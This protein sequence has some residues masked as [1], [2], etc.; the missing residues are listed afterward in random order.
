MVNVF[1][2]SHTFFSGFNNSVHY[3]FQMIHLDK[4]TACCGCH[5]CVSICPAQCIQMIPDTE[6]FLYPVPDES[7]CIDCGLCESVCPVL[8][9]PVQAGESVAFAAWN[10]D[11]AVREDSSSGGIFNAL[12]QRTFEKNGV[13]FGAAF[14]GSMTLCHQA[15]YNEA[16]GRL[17]RGSKYLQSVI[18]NAYLEARK[19]L[20]QG[21]QVLFSGTPCQI[22]G[23]YAFLRK[24]YDNLLT[25]D[26]VCHGV[27]SPKVFSAYRAELEGQHGAKAQRIA[28]RR[29]SIA[30]F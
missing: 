9:P 14:D 4:K 28:F 25:C 23:L 17:L 13:V 30:V 24:G 8:N 16:E 6:G 5:A 12:M 11:E 27:P 21:R 3:G 29:K 18:G 10:R 19:Y 1:A 15:A 20:K 2:L 22:A 7:L 26:V